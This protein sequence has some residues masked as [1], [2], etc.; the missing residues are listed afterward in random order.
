MR[1]QKGQAISVE[2]VLMIL[3]FMAVIMI[4]T[5]YVR[6]ALQA[7]IQ[8]AS[9]TAV[10]RA[11]QVSQT[12]VLP[13]YEPYYSETTSETD[14]SLVKEERITPAGTMIKAMTSMMGSKGNSKQAA[15][16]N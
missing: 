3:M 5:V 6:R 1:R 9:T 15:P 13:E 16:A 8:D 4:M 7:R 10:N 12:T 11:A 14:R 2:Y